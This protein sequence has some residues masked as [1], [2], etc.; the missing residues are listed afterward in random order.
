MF[1]TTA[2]GAQAY[3]VGLVEGAAETTASLLR[4]VSGY[5]SDKV[6]KRKPLILLGYS[7]STITKPLFAF[8]NVWFFVLFVRVI[9]RIGKGIRTVPRDAL[10]A[11]SSD[12]T[13]RGKAFGLQRAMDGIG[14]MLGAV[15]AFLLLP[16]L[17]FRNTFLFAFLPGILAVVAILFVKEKRAPVSA[18]NTNISIKLSFS[19]LSQNL[20][21]FI[22]ASSLFSIGHFG[23]AFLLLRVLDIGLSNETAIFLYMLFYL[24]HSLFSVPLGIVSDRIGRKA[25]L[26]MGYALFIALAVGFYFARDIYSLLICFLAYGLFFA[27]IDGVQ[28]AFVVDLSPAHLKA[29]AL[30]TF[31]AATGLV[32]LPAAFIIGLIWERLSPEASFLYG[33]FFALAALIVLLFVKEKERFLK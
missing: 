28:R 19:E 9:E 16:V 33:A 22:L 31:H 15:L 1:L 29:T 23:Y 30:G 32:A 11:E 6:K 7:L 24:S 3:I 5:W 14:S 17:G 21:V 13:V 2:L 10:I 25:V 20:R 12:E 26:S 8:A 4:I 27:M 18:L